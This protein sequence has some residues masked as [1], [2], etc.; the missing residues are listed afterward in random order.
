MEQDRLEAAREL[1]EQRVQFFLNMQM[2]FSKANNG[3]TLPVYPPVDFFPH[4]DVSYQFTCIF[5]CEATSSLL[6]CSTCKSPS[7]RWGVV[8]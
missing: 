8:I 1:D 2:E 4:A 6:P 5:S 7:D 3:A